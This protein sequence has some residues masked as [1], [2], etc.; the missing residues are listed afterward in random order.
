MNMAKS[1]SEDRGRDFSANR[2][3]DEPVPGS[4]GRTMNRRENK[5]EIEIGEIADTPHNGATSGGT[6]S[7]KVLQKNRKTRRAA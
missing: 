5:D 1:F 3:A 7:P 4:R 2:S 6:R